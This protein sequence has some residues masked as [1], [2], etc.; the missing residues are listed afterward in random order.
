MHRTTIFVLTGLVLVLGC[1]S[2]ANAASIELVLVVDGSGSI[3]A[4]EWNLQMEG[5]HDAILAAVPTDGSVAIGG[6]IFAETV[7]AFQGLTV[8]TAGNIG[9]IADAFLNASRAGLGSLTNISGGIAA[10]EGIF[11]DTATKS[12]I[13][14]STD[15][16]FTASIS[17]D[18][19]GP[20]GTVGTA[21]W[22][23]ANSADV[24]NALGIGVTPNFA[25]FETA[26]ESKIEREA[27]VPEPGTMAL[28][29]LGLLGLG[30]AVI[31]RRRS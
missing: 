23:V 5:Y 18:P 4:T 2:G 1:V 12:I 27:G 9:T 10:A 25:S 13:D 7:S 30:G 19:A 24:L 31:R 28:L 17:V 6:V 8:I 14:V 21:A 26:L 3:N 16:A 15:G 29:G 20:A 22:A 11:S